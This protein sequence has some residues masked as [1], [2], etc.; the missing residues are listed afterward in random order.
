MRLMAV[1]RFE[2]VWPPIRHFFYTFH[3]LEAVDRVS[4]I[5]LQVGENLGAQFSTQRG[6]IEQIDQ[7]WYIA[8]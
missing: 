4:E 6:E 5:Q 8:W 3:P 2:S 7:C 1:L